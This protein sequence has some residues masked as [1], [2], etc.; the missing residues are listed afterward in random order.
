M[1]SI[2]VRDP[3]SLP[4]NENGGRNNFIPN[5]GGETLNE[6][7]EVQRKANPEGPRLYSCKD[8]MHESASVDIEQGVF[9]A[10]VT[11]KDWEVTDEE[12]SVSG[13]DVIE[14]RGLSYSIL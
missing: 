6:R 3:N 13:V 2:R 5:E 8:T 4:N 1:C 11:W 7:K 9:I 14:F 12:R 10:G